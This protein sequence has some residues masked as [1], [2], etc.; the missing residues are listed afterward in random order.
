MDSRMR[1]L[2]R[3]VLQGDPGAWEPFA[4]ERERH[5]L[6]AL[7]RPRRHAGPPLRPRCEDARGTG[8]AGDQEGICPCCAPLTTDLRRALHRS[9]R[10]DV[11]QRLRR[12]DLD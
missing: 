7:R 5:G 1:A 6:P 8:G 9:S 3:L 2:H 4:R 12:P 10:R 11:R